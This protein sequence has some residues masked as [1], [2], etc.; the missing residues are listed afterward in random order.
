[1][2][3]FNL[4]YGR[5]EK[6]ISLPK[7]R[8]LA[9][10][11]SKAH[12]FKPEGTESEIVRK[13]LANPIDSK[14]L[15]ELVV[16]KENV[17]II[18]SDHT[19][20]VPSHV[21]MPILLEEIRKG[22]PDA[23]ITILVATG[24]HRATT[25]EELIDKYGEEIA[26]NENFIIHDSQDDSQ[27]VKVGILPSGGELI[28]NKA[29]VEADLL[30]AEG[31]IEPHFF[32]GFSGGRK[33]ILPGI[34]SKATVLANHCSE[35]VGS[36]YAR[37]GNLEGNPLHKDMLYAAEKANLAFIL[38]VVID[39]HKKV[40]AAFAGDREEAH[41]TGCEFVKDL[42][43]VNAV[44]ADIGIVTNGGYPLDQ[45]IYQSVKGMTAAEA[46]VADNGVIIM[47]SSCNDGHGGEEFYE[48]FKNS[49]SVKEIMDEIVARKR[50]ETISDQWEAQVLAR[51]LLKYSII[52]VTDAPRK[53]I[54]DM[55]MKWAP[56]VEAAL[57]MADEILG[58]K[59][60][61]ITVIPDG[62]S[63]VVKK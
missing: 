48:T 53:M 61:K 60:G 45:N 46:T 10:L 20:P 40:I 29:A 51:L 5:G 36:K 50:H 33:S 52:M 55:Y 32:A 27:L 30:I 18:S 26:N 43:G 9:K 13:A 23:K 4:P 59:D 2:L 34:A 17:V 47:A 16:G 62:V 56:S 42:A 3:T 54:E 39:S 8:I 22:N 24:M 15:S 19:R 37:T 14:P 63:V 1:M 38:N 28:I 35:F 49:N 21:T 57:E 11:E 12:D 7:E 41:Y 58:T 6:K 25:K 44:K 31:F